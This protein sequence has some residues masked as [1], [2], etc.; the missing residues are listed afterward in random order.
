MD[1]LAVGGIATTIAATIFHEF[2]KVHQY[3]GAVITWLASSAAAD[4]CITAFLVWSLVNS[5]F[6]DQS[7]GVKSYLY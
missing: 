2:A 1:S 3:D 7:S 5:H 4:I 6:G